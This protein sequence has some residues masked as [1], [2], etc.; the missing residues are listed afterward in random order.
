MTVTAFFIQDTWKASSRLTVNLGL[1]YGPPSLYTNVTGNMMNWYPNLN[2][3]VV[4]KSTYRPG[5]FPGLPIVE[6]STLRLNPPFTGAEI[7]EPAAGKTP[8]LTFD[9]R[10]RL[11]KE[12]FPVAP[13]STLPACYRYPINLND[14]PPSPGPVQPNPPYQPLR[15]NHRVR[16]STGRTARP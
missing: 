8:T 6:G 4:L 14:P 2:E 11:G 16:F 9:N 12:R 13:P 15:I 10:S 7:F 3:I 5:L 1:R